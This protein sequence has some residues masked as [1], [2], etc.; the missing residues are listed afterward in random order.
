MAN[1]INVYHSPLFFITIWFTLFLTH[2]THSLSPHGRQSKSYPVTVQKSRTVEE[3]Q[4]SLHQVHFLQTCALKWQAFWTTHTKY[5]MVKCG[6]TYCKKYSQ[7]EK[8]RISDR[9]ISGSDISLDRQCE[10]AH[11]GIRIFIN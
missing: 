11:L 9:V 1:T 4:L 10:L 3:M 2:W 6:Y 7:V 5:A 8:R